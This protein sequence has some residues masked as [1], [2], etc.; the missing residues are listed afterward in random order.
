MT[1]TVYILECADGKLYTGITTDLL[2]RIS[3]HETGRGARF[4]KG[5]GPFRLVYKEPCKSRSA[6]AKRELEIKAKTRTEK[7]AMILA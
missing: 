7:L 6:A 3:E 2:R 5:R 1:W 4:T